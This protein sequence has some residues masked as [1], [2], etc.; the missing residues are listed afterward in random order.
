VIRIAIPG[1]QASNPDPLPGERIADGHEQDRADKGDAVKKSTIV[2]LFFA[3]ALGVTAAHADTIYT[4]TGNAFGN[5]DPNAPAGLTR[6]SGSLTFAAPLAANLPLSVISTP[7]TATFS[8]GLHSS[9]AIGGLLLATDANGNIK[10]WQFSFSAVCSPSDPAACTVVV[11]GTNNFSSHDDE[12]FASDAFFNHLWIRESHAN[13]GTWS[14]ST[15]VATVPEPASS[16]LLGSGLLGFFVTAGGRRRWRLKASTARATL[17]RIRVGL[18][19]VVAGICLLF[20]ALPLRAD[21]NYSYTGSAYTSTQNAFTT[22]M[23]VNG[24]VTFSSPLAPNLGLTSMTPTSWGFTDG[25]LGFNSLPP[26]FSTFPQSGTFQFGT[27]AFGNINAWHFEVYLQPPSNLW[28]IISDSSTGD[29]ATNDDLR[30]FFNP[31]FSTA[32]TQT[33]GTWSPGTLAATPEPAT[34][35]LLA[36]GTG[37]LGLILRRKA[38]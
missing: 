19:P 34:L 24:F 6:I 7:F 30:N 37:T 10:L 8:D 15:T 23:S 1:H 5:D 18:L 14:V 3:L 16:A 21:F 11:F 26:E 2:L 31:V 4:Y 35:S 9:S 22:S 28:S 20:A 29:A 38:A 12:S 33:A 17:L 36:L 13:P 32:T 25:L 27:D